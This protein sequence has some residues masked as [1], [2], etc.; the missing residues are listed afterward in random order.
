MDESLKVCQGE[1]LAQHCGAS[2]FEKARIF[3][4]LR[5]PTHEC[6]PPQHAWMLRELGV[7]IRSA[8]IRRLPQER[9]SKREAIVEP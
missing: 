9:G 5:R 3:R 7:G 6:Q 2:S 8:G 4:R 1:R